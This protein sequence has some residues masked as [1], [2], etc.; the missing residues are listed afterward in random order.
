MTRNNNQRAV[1]GRASR[2]LLLAFVSATSVTAASAQSVATPGPDTVAESA[3][4]APQGDIV[5][6]ATRRQES[7]SKVPTSVTVFGSEQLKAIGATNLETVLNLVPS[8]VFVGDSGYR[9]SLT[10]RGVQGSNEDAAVAMYLDGVYVGRDVAQNIPLV[11]AESVQI[12]RGPQG[13]LYGKN[14]LGGAIIVRSRQP[15]Y[16]TQLDASLKIQ[17]YGYFGGWATVTGPI[18][19]D[20]VAALVTVY[21]SADTGDF[22]NT[23]NNTHVNDAQRIGGRV[24]VNGKLSDTLK[25]DLAG[26]Y[27]YDGSRVDNIKALGVYNLAVTPAQ[28]G[29]TG[30]NNR[31]S[32]NTQG[33]G[34]REIYGAQATLTWSIDPFTVSAVTAY[35]GYNLINNRDFDGTGANDYNFRIEQHQ[36]QFSQEITLISPGHKRF[37]WLMGAQY[38]S[39]RFNSKITGTDYVG[40]LLFAS[41]QAPPVDFAA[42][43]PS[44]NTDSYGAYLQGDFEIVRGLK[45]AAGLR[46]SYDKRT[47]SKDDR[48]F[49]NGGTP[50]T[51]VVSSGKDH[52]D[53]WLPEAS[54]TY[55][56]TPHISIYG[57]YAG[58]YR[59]GGYNVNFTNS[60]NNEFKKETSQSYEGGLK[61]SLLGGRVSGSLTGYQI[62]WKDQQLTGIGAIGFVTANGDSK[63]HG[64][65]FDSHARLTDELTLDGGVSWLKATFGAASFSV[66]DP[67]SRL[68]SSVNVVGQPLLRA[69]EWSGSIGA[70]YAQRD[71]GKGGIVA[72]ADVAYVGDQYLVIGRPDLQAPSIVR[73][74]ARLG[75]KTDKW[76][77]IAFGTNL[78]NRY[79]LYFAQTSAKFDT[80]GVTAP[81]RFGLEFRFHYR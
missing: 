18:V 49:V 59:P 10:I 55:E 39:D 32:A 37:N 13:A 19:S 4:T 54:L 78:L 66:R 81:R 75:Y 65:E 31:I 62:I 46:Y 1:A 33:V 29:D 6:T 40:S 27:S 57:K 79:T 25:L 76:E 9:T 44:Y 11:D 50:F 67:I 70:T 7:I 12:L 35:R 72:H 41:P 69:P 61:W 47:Y 38:F 2:Y 3:G 43:M 51:T 17:N 14:T 16:T 20:K 60:S 23:T 42:L 22:Y 71:T 80:I 77:V 63:S 68:S 53:G 36:H 26:D 45:A 5:V 24:A 73:L 15:S 52:W 58:S 8:V 64:I 28:L 30:I 48:T 21:S 34:D 74:N 56:I